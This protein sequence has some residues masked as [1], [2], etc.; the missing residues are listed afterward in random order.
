MVAPNNHGPF[1]RSLLLCGLLS[2]VLYVA[3]DFV[4]ALSYPGYDY[5]AQ[6][7]S[8]MSAIGAPTT[9]LL[10]P[11]YRVWSLLFLAFTAGVWTVGRM[12]HPLRWCAGLM[13]AV[14]VVGSGFSLFPMTQRSAAPTFSDTMH[15]VVAGATML[16]LSG[17]ILAGGMAFERGFRRYSAATVGV[18]LV[19]F[20][21][22]MR[23]VPSVAAD[24]PTP[25]MGLNERVSMV[26]WLLW[27]AAL[28][29]Q[30]LRTGRT[31]TPANL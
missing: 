2:S 29:V 20:V 3:I 5:S 21:Q 15:L 28:S 11:L 4:G 30:V 16:L 13:I 9:D 26:A 25:Y 6:A 22:T 27:I 8:E 12:R 7:I 10:A 23:D 24:L 19:F 1:V 18:M 14:A 31:T 17:A